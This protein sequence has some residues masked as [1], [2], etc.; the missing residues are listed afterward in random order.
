LNFNFEPYSGN[1]VFSPLPPEKWLLDA[2]E[3]N[4]LK[5]I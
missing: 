5:E 3:E 1:S 4:Q 2:D